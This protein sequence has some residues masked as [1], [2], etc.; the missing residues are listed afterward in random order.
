MY[1][2]SI[3]NWFLKNTY[4]DNTSK[5]SGNRVAGITDA[6]GRF[7][8]K[9]GQN[10]LHVVQLL[11]EWFSAFGDCLNSVGNAASCTFSKF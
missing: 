8:Q 5:V 10:V 2:Y 6:F 3:K 7:L 1:I 4:I 9:L 11:I